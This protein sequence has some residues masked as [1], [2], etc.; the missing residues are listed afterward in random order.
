MP[1]IFKMVLDV[2]GAIGENFISAD[3]EVSYIEPLTPFNMYNVYMD[4]AYAA[5]SE[6]REKEPQLVVWNGRTQIWNNKRRS[7]YSQP[8]RRFGVEL[9]GGIGT[10]AQSLPAHEKFCGR[11]T[12]S[13]LTI[14]QPFQLPGP[15]PNPS[16]TFTILG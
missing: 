8:Q 15:W 16:F 9:K 13:P 10:S 11:A 4:E 2:R 6:G 7:I 14:V 3:I 5:D 12:M 1:S